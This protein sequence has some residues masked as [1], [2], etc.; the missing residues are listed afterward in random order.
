MPAFRF[1]ALHTDGKTQKG[2]LEGDSARQ[3]RS[4]LR[5]QGLTPLLVEEVAQ[6]GQDKG[7]RAIRL[8]GE[9]SNSE[10]VLLTRQLA[11]LLQAR[12]PLAR[13]LGALVE[14]AEKPLIR[15][16]LASIRSDVTSGTPLS[17]A[18]AKYPKAFGE[19]YTATIAAGE[20]T[21]DLGRVLAKLADALEAKQ[22]LNQK[23]T[24]AFIYPAVVTLVAIMAETGLLT[25]VVR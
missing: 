11:S 24:T 21:G 6:P 12:L 23:V 9:L 1:E 3:V 7:S 5:L 20:S 8:G 22:A 2:M 16:R 19:M 15:E 10:V 18:F 4:Q 14:Q 13:A 17:Q 25:Y